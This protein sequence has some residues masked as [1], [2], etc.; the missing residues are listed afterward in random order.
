MRRFE[1]CLVDGRLPKWPTGALC[2]SVGTV[3]PRFESWACHVEENETAE[4]ERSIYDLGHF[5]GDAFVFSK[6]F[7]MPGGGVVREIDLSRLVIPEGSGITRADLILA[8]T[9]PHAI[10]VPASEDEIPEEARKTLR[11]AKAADSRPRMRM[12]PASGKP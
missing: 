9:D 2:K 8:L 5:D 1:S 7:R 3:L 6:P 4:P 12:P 11:R 10:A